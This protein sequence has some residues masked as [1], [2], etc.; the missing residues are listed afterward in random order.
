MSLPA[1]NTLN[2]LSWHG[3]VLR[4]HRTTGRLIHALPWPVR[5]SGDDWRLELP[6]QGVVERVASSADPELFLMPAGRHGLLHFERVGHYL[7]AE[8]HAGEVRFSRTQP[9]IWE[10]FMVVSAADLARLR[11]L[12]GAHWRDEGEGDGAAP[13]TLT[14]FRVRIG[15]CE[16]DLR[17]GI[18]GPQAGS[19]SFVDPLSGRR[20]EQTAVPRRAGESPLARRRHD[21]QATLV[22][23]AAQFRDTP[24]SRVNIPGERE[25]GFLPCAVSRADE[26]WMQSAWLQGG[27]RRLGA[28]TLAAQAV[29]ETDKYV[30]MGRGHEGQIFDDAGSSNENG[31]L[32][33]NVRV[34]DDDILRREGDDVYISHD[35]LEAAPHLAGAYA[36]FCN[37]H[38]S[39]YYHWV[40]DAMLPLHALAPYL[41]AGTKL[42]LPATLDGFQ[43]GL[44]GDPAASVKHRDILAAWGFGD[45]PSVEVDS[46]VCHVEEVYWIDRAMIEE[47]PGRL[48]RAARAH[49]LSRLGLPEALP[50]H[51]PKRIYAARRGP[52]SVENKDPV[53][54]IAANNGFSVA[55]MEELSPRAQ[56][57][58]FAGA[59]FVIGPHGAALSNLLFCPP[60]AKVIEFSPD[61]QYRPLF[62]QISDKVGLSHAVLPCPTHDGSFFGHLHVDVMKFRTLLSQMLMR[63]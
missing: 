15:N 18:P 24:D 37:G 11:R 58:L 55:Y 21:L 23:D 5:P 7:C 16:I 41:P 56:I 57:E 61:C 50:E 22:Q 63:L 47:M 8:P 35:A 29:R 39:N 6:P 25:F 34:V 33:S 19:Q 60:G 42:L 36:V 12:M 59:E 30:L 20:F 52:R 3:T 51:A 44:H 14:D 46:P 31:Y 49:V 17:G 9:G 43:N 27:P 54:R 62:A 48:V 1:G 13:V 26:D 28:A 4:L 38:L 53:E 32:F 10:T 2:C 45:F 40:I